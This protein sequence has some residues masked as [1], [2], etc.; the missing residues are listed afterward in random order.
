MLIGFTTSFRMGQLLGYALNVPECHADVPVERYMATTFMDSVRACLKAGG[1]SKKENEVEKGGTFLVGYR[2]RIFLVC[3]DFQVAES[4]RDFDSC[5]AGYMLA[6]G[7][8]YSSAEIV[9]EARVRLA[10]E[11]AEAFCPSV[12]GPMVIEKLP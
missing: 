6:L 3:D 12:R 7:S 1:F 5:G 10:L 9:P 4:S 11:A 8:L 2:G